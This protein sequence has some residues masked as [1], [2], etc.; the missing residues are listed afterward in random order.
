MFIWCQKVLIKRRI[1]ERWG[2]RHRVKTSSTLR[3]VKPV[4]QGIAY[5]DPYYAALNIVSLNTTSSI[6]PSYLKGSTVCAILPISLLRLNL[7]VHSHNHGSFTEWWWWGA[8][9]QP[10]LRKHA[11]KSSQFSAV[12]THTKKLMTFRSLT[13]FNG[14]DQVWLMAASC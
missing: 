10:W 5:P 14:A 8:G 9:L 1:W 13:F 2:V 7:E 6:R 3:T 12:K 11:E 4:W